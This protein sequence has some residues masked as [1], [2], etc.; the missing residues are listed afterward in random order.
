MDVCG[1]LVLSNSVTYVQLL[2]KLGCL[3]ISHCYRTVEVSVLSHFLPNSIL[4]IKDVINFTQQV[5]LFS[6]VSA[7][8]LLNEIVSA[9]ISENFLW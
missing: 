7:R 4:A 2:A 1:S 6:K 9:S 8:G 5:P 3:K